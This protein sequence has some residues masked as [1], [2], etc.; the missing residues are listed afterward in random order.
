MDGFCAVVQ[1]LERFCRT[2]S[3]VKEC[4]EWYPFTRS[5]VRDT[6]PVVQAVVDPVES[7]AHIQD[8]AEIVPPRSLIDADNYLTGIAWRTRQLEDF[9]GSNRVF[10]FWVSVFVHCLV[11]V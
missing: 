1:Q 3:E 2:D 9:D 4:L 5:A 7:R 11:V 10:A 8:L 6:H